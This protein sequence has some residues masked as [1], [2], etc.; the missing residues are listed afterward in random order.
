[1]RDRRTLFMVAVLPLLLYPAMGIGMVQMTVLFSEQPRNVV[2]LGAND[3]PKQPQLLEGDHFV[4]NWFRIPSDADKL[5]VITDKESVEKKG[6]DTEEPEGQNRQDLLKQARDLESVFGKQK[7]LLSRLQQIE[8]ESKVEKATRLKLK[9]ELKAANTE[10]SA[11]F[12]ESQI[13]VL[14]LIPKG[15]SQEI[16]R[17]SEKLARHEPIDF[18]PAEALRP[19]YL[20]NSADEKTRI[21][22][23]QVQE[24]MSAY[25]KDILRDR[26]NRANLPE[27]LPTPINPIVIDLAQDEQ[28]AANLWSKLFPALLIIMAATGAFYPAIDLGAGEKERGTMETLLISPAKR[29]EIVLGKFLT[30]MIFS[31]S[32]ALLNLASMGFTGKH[33]VNMVGSGALSKMGDLSFP[34]F[35]ALFWIVVLLIPLSALFSALC[36]SLA[37][38]ARSSKEG[39]YYLT[40]L[41]M[42][43]IGLTVF[44]L[45]PGVEINAFYSFMPVVGVAL[46]L[47]AM[48][49]S[50]V[51][52][53]A[54]Y[55]YAIPVLFTSVG[56]SLLALWWAIDQFQREDVL[57]REAERFEVGL[58]L[59]HLMHTKGPL[60][61]FAEAGFCFVIIMLLQFAV[62]NSMRDAIAYASEAERPTR[63]MQLLMIQQLAIIATPAL[64]MGI[65]LTTSLRK[66]FRLYLP[67][68]GFLAVGIVLPFLL[69]PISLELASSLGWFF[70][71]LP[72]G[73]MGALKNMSD[74]TQPIWLILM[75]FALAPAICEELAFRGFILSGFGRRGR[76]WLAII[77]SSVTFG[78]M[79][80]IPQQ[81]FNATLLGL[82][83]GL[84]AVHSRSLLPGV[85][86]HFIYNG[87]SV[88]RSRIP[89][90]WVP[91]GGLQH[92]VRMEPD[93][94]RYSWPLLLICGVITIVLLLW[95]QRQSRSKI[96]PETSQ[97]SGSIALDRRLTDSK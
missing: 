64:I 34:S 69:H 29:T 94:L 19:I 33:M 52:A 23:G 28:L 15:L 2:I 24:V 36:L 22:F 20:E 27:S 81:V 12:A 63:M 78:A 25:E 59:K 11:L 8:G 5:R 95:V 58:W 13:Q 75:A 61:S 88:F 96:D 31:V 9:E 72:S 44:C 82:V 93:G 32:T 26:L 57:F 70:P 1:M 45:S 97:T 67:S 49:L 90:N 84:V 21:A 60:P 76:A 87:L 55:I 18:D 46:L 77:L 14:I 35:T 40:P 83:L 47:K 42:V 37:T 43:T 39:Q 85:I 6:E 86:F 74:P 48:L 89:E 56:Y 92:F 65:M 79:H 73:A 10:F 53:G 80:M 16:E 62:M 71:K 66:T 91:T 50:T 38:F 54:L 3:L 68:L 41:L 7:E 17:V 30:V 4:S 51:N